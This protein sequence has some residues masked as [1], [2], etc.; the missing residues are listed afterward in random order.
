MGIN[1]Q[2]KMKPFKL[3]TENVEL[4]ISLDPKF[5]AVSGIITDG[6]TRNP[7]PGA[8]VKL[9]GETIITEADG[10]YNFIG[11]PYSG[12]LSLMIIA[13]DYQP[14]TENFQLRT[15]RVGLNIRL[16][17]ATD[18]KMEI[19][20]LLERFSALI[21]SLDIRKL[22]TI[23]ELFS[24]SYVA[25]DD[26]T[27]LL[28]LATGVIPAKFDDVSQTI[29]VVFEKYDALQFQFKEIDVD[30]TNSRQASARFTLHIISEEGP[31][32]NKREILVDCKIDFRKEALVWKIVFWQLFNVE[33]LL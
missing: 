31:R 15:D 21:E 4:N 22:G 23:Q 18:P 10:K 2:P 33:F 25:S 16:M 1:H 14:R 27:T 7:I 3:R 5:G 11:I 8:T 28:G 17:P 32:P 12:D 26:P 24:E 13:T 29:I 30:V 19:T 6:T 9:L 20:Q